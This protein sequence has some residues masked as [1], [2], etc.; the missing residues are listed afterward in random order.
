VLSWEDA[1]TVGDEDHKKAQ[2]EA[3]KFAKELGI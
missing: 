3:V 2:R 1:Q